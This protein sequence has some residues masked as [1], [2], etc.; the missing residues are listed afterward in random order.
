MEGKVGVL[1]ECSG[2]GG[3]EGSDNVKEEQTGVKR[4]EGRILGVREL[5]WEV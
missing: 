4:G 2:E 3:F 1:V 5:V